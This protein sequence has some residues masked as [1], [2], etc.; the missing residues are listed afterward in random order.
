MTAVVMVSVEV[1]Y[2]SVSLVGGV[3][4]AI[5]SLVSV[6]MVESVR[7]EESVSVRM[8]TLAITVKS[9]PL[10]I[11]GVTTNPFVSM[12]ACYNLSDIPLKVLHCHYCKTV[13]LC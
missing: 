3:F 12:N 1:E 7:M 10:P 9:I 6:R 13:K 2:A 8:A 4:G 11:G 5:R